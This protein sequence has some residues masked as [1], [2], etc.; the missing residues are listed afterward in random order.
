[1]SDRDIETIAALE[2]HRFDA[3]A[4]VTPGLDRRGRAQQH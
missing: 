3:V 4:T 2:R 1:M